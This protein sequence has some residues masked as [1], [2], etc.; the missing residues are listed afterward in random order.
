[1]VVFRVRVRFRIGLGLEWVRL[2]VRVGV[3]RD[4]GGVGCHPSLTPTRHG[5]SSHTTTERSEG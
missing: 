1:M 5:L 3:G 4:L 2:V